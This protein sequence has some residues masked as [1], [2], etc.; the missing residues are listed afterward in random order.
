MNF[1]K[2]YKHGLVI[3]I[4]GIFYMACFHYLETRQ[5]SAYH[6]IHCVADDWIPFCEYFIVP[7]FLWFPYQF[8]VIAYMIFKNPDKREYYRLTCNLCMGMSIFLFVSWVYPNGQ[9]LRPVVFPRDNIFTTLTA[10]LYAT[11]TPTNILPSIHVFNSL[12]T[13]MAIN[14]CQA[15]REKKAL[16]IFCGVLTASI[17]LSTLF[18]KQHSI[19]DATLGATMACAGYLLFY[20]RR[21]TAYVRRHTY[22]RS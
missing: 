10:F 12:A 16:R 3:V 2:K 14:N 6:L 1:L 15:L 22:V 13:F 17:V 18:L 9:L 20:R 11:D 7:Y 4:Y 8:I 21:T 5:L 19:I